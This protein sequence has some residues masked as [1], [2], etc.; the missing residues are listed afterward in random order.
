M[1]RGV[2]AVKE[3]PAT[4]RMS[5]RGR[6]IRG[7]AILRPIDQVPVVPGGD[8][9]ETTGAWAYY[10]RLDGATITDA[11]TCYPNGGIPDIDN[12]SLRNRY[13]T[14]AEYYRERQR[15]RGLEFI[16]S[17]L[18]EQGMARLVEVLESNRDDEILFLEEE[19][20]DARDVAKSS[21]L[22]DVRN[23]AKRRVL[24]LTRRLETIRQ[25]FDP[26]E[27]LAELNEIARAQQ[28]A[29]VDP[30]VLRVMRSMIGE[31]NDR[32]LEKIAHFQTGGITSDAGESFEGVGHIE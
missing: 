16:G 23:Q 10:I 2:P 26:D 17:K 20:A 19:I 29:K 14:N 9:Y 1:P 13:G 27:L 7:E 3:A 18:T 25:G 24:Q 12:V 6:R 8:R 4:S 31:S 28:L 11:L 30:N 32:M 21:D 5:E 15:R 22:P